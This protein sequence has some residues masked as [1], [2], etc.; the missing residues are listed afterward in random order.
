[1]N[2]RPIIG[3][4]LGDASGVGPEIVAKLIARG[5]TESMCRPVIIGDIRTF[6]A[7]LRTFGGNAEYYPIRNIDEADWTKG[8]PILD[9]GDQDPQRI[10]YGKFDSYC[11]T[12][13]INM[14]KL[15][16]GL[17]KKRKIAGFCFAPFNKTALKMCGCKVESEHY[18]MAEE[19]GVAGPFG[20]INVVDKL[21]SVR[22]TS[23]IPI[24]EVAKT[25]KIEKI[26]STIEL[27]NTTAKIFGIRSP[28][29]GVA[30]LNPHCG[31]N[32]KCGNEEIDVIQPAI[33][34]AQASEIDVKGPYSSDVL[35]IKAFN[36]EFDV[37][38]TMYHDQGQI[39]L[40]LVGFD[41]GIT[42]SG[43]MPYPIATCAH[44][45]AYDLAGKG[46]AKTSA[47]EH[48]VAFVSQ[49]AWV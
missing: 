30:A 5:I 46:I 27:G 21:M 18:L 33:Y 2:N 6:E 11:G 39:A 35:F 9:T 13:C 45:T 36:G 19:F 44:G 25:I 37:T 40:K 17:C 29:I 41:R 31:E 8:Y 3:L 47:F 7:G 43:G 10:T 1:M 48:A 38:V 12:A 14:L 22:V 49:A 28:R 4:L 34:K 16:C 26:L 42:V 24:K 20:E 23:H 15:A 32:G